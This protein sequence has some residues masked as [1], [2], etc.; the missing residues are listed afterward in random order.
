[1]HN[2][3]ASYT[4]L[5]HTGGNQWPQRFVAYVREQRAARGLQANSQTLAA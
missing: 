5:R 2:V 4:H 3:L 1:V